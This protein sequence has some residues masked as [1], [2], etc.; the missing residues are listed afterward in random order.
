MPYVGLDRDTAPPPRLESLMMIIIRL[1]F[2]LGYIY[3]WEFQMRMISLKLYC[4]FYNLGFKVRVLQG[5]YIALYSGVVKKFN[6]ISKN[7]NNLFI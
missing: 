2:K 7:I 1:Y 4:L 6:C 3:Y 5:G